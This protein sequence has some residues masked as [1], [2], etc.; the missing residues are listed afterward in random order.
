M[1]APRWRLARSV[2]GPAIIAEDETS[3]AGRAGLD[4]PRD[5]LGYIE[6]TRE[7]RLIVDDSQSAT[8]WR[9]SSAR[10]CGT[11]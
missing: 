4:G 3:H 6:L 5:G 9:R 10:S 8:R 11:A 7:D 1:T 2:A